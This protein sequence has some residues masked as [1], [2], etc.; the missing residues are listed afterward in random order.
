MWS[1]RFNHVSERYADKVGLEL[2]STV[3]GTHIISE[4]T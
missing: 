3:F 2:Q 1:D 4:N